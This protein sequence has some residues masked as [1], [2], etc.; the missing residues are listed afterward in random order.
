[1]GCT[2]LDK[3]LAVLKH[4]EF[5][6]YIR[7]CITVFAARVSGRDDFRLWNSQFISYAG[8]LQPDGSVIGD[9]ARVSL[10]RVSVSSSLPKI[11]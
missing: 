5:T 11:H 7:S 8:Y 2:K 3:S 4:V 6:F 10:T 1:M 9:P